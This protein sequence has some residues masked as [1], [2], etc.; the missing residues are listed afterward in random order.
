M[1][2]SRRSRYCNSSR[3]MSSSGSRRPSA[4]GS[5][6]VVHRQERLLAIGIDI[7]RSLEQPRVD[8]DQPAR[9][10]GNQPVTNPSGA[11]K[12]GT[13]AASAT[14]TTTSCVTCGFI[15]E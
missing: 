1:A 3:R 11:F 5:C 12:G 15:V 14:S 4:R 9:A 6:T 7:Q 8:W 2:N 13:G 10:I